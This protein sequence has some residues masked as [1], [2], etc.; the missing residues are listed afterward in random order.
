MKL[1]CVELNWISI[2]L[3]WKRLA[4][5]SLDL[6]WIDLSWAELNWVDLY[7]I[8]W[9]RLDGLDWI[10]SNWVEHFDNRNWS[11]VQWHDLNW[12]D[13]SLLGLPWIGLNVVEF[14]WH[15]LARIR[16]IGQERLG[17]DLL[18][19][20]SNGWTGL[21]MDR[22]GLHYIELNWITLHCL[23]LTSLEVKRVL[24]I[25]LNCIKFNLDWL[26]LIRLDLCCIDLNWLER[27]WT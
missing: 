18:E 10:D 14:R 13:W 25:A 6:M 9:I 16:R 2:T 26:E 8:E 1:S 27:H 15:E 3:N 4:L 19:F 5:N 12:L 22:I 21:D 23:D 7:W 11:E 17:F 20:I 24:K